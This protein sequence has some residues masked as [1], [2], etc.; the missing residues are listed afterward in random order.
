MHKQQGWPQAW[1]YCQVKLIQTLGRASQ[2]VNWSWSE[3]IKSHHAQTSSG[4]GL[5]SHFWNRNIVRSI[6]PGLK[7]KIT[8]LL[9]TGPKSSFQMKVHF[10]F[11]FGNQGPRVW[12]KSGEAHNPCC[13]KSSGKFP[14][15]VMIWAVMSSAGIGPLCFLKSSQCSH[16]PGNFRALHASF[17]WQALW[18]CW[19]RFPAWLGTCPH[20]QRYQK[21]VQGPW[22]YCA[23]LASKLAWPEPHWESMGYCQEEDERHQIQQFRW[24]EGRYQSNLDF[25]YTWAVPQADCL[26]ATPHWCSNSCKR[27]PNQVLS[28]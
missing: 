7:R 16:L 20:Y 5:P 21:L 28:A 23:W 11:H 26:Y 9:L 15:S 10:A 6:L 12:R 4:K 27:R 25:C 1:E 3:C 19:F 18:R 8:G 24:P 17:C 13:L 2:G 14:Q 22:C